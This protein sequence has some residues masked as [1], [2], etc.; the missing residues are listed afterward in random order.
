MKKTLV[1][2]LITVALFACQKGLDDDPKPI[3]HYGTVIFY[4]L[5]PEADK[6]WEVYIDGSSN[7]TGLVPYTVIEPSCE[8]PGVLGLQVSL[9]EG[10]HSVLLKSLQ[11]F[12]SRSE[13]ITV[14]DGCHTFK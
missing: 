10:N 14:G 9:K 1:A 6:Q 2:A 5:N 7:R 4:S 8:N 13:D 12:A 3:I 11:G